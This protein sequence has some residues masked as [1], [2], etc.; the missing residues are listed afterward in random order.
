MQDD[1]I[2]G[3][4]SVRENLYF[5]AALRLPNSM[6]WS[7]KRGRVDKVINEL[8]LT[9]C[10]DTKVTKRVRGR[11]RKERGGRE[12]RERGEGK[13]ARERGEGG[14]RGEGERSTYNVFY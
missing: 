12:E 13:R 10:A 11:G 9:S 6:K 1:V 14:E 2:M 7:E 4:L 3:T 5:S 8:G